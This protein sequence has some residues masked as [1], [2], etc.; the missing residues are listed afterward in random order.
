MLKDFN[1]CLASFVLT[2]SYCL[3]FY[4]INGMNEQEKVVSVLCV[5]SIVSAFCVE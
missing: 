5:V 1:G 4:P 3:S 2:R